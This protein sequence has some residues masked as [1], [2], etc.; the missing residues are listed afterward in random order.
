MISDARGS[1]VNSVR[2]FGPQLIEVFYGLP[3]QL[4][5]RGGVGGDLDRILDLGE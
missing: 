3:A 4:L 2:A 5:A 1:R